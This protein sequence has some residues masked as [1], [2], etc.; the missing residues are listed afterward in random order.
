MRQARRALAGIVVAALAGLSCG[1]S[2]KEAFAESYCDLLEP[3]CGMAGLSTSGQA[4]RS[5]VSLGLSSSSFDKGAGDACLAELRA[6]AARAD[7]CQTFGSQEPA[8]C[9]KA[10][11]T[12][13]GTKKVGETCDF[14][15]DCAPSSEGPTGCGHAF[16]GGMS[17]DKCQLQ[18]QGKAGDKPCAGTVEG[19]VTTGNV[20]AEV[21]ER[22]F[23]CNTADGV[24]CDSATDACVALK[25]IGDACT[26]SSGECV[27]GAYCD[28]TQR[29][30]LARKPAGGA[31]KMDVFQ[32]RECVEG[33][34]CSAAGACAAQ[35]AIGAACT[36][37][38]ECRSGNCDAGKCGLGFGDLGLGLLCGTK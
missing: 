16:A 27:S 29:K 31:C 3:C 25:M 22:A 15:D 28:G 24:R 35:A 13:N 9:E 37:S 6:A 4:C 17:I 26:G 14:D 32:S 1:K 10:F 30:C 11:G 21:P 36:D 33:H 34:H 7:F 5:L 2:D 20:G 18:L 19:A 12:N 23:L 8:S 38:D